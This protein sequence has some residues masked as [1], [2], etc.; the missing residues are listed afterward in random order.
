MLIPDRTHGQAASRG[1]LPLL[2]ITAGLAFGVLAQ[3]PYTE[4][5]LQRFDE[6]YRQYLLEQNEAW[7]QQQDDTIQLRAAPAADAGRIQFGYSD[8][9]MQYQDEW[10]RREDAASRLQP[11][12][13][14]VFRLNF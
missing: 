12:P 7:R 8:D 2:V 11:R 6:S 10:F 4:Q 5:Y 9:P 13:N 1:G 3:P 14:T